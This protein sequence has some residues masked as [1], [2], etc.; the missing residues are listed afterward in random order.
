MYFFFHA[1]K[2]ACAFFLLSKRAA[3]FDAELL[4]VLV[5]ELLGP[6]TGLKSGGGGGR[7]STAVVAAFRGRFVGGVGGC[8]SAA[9]GGGGRDD[10]DAED[11]VRSMKGA[12]AGGVGMESC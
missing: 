5:A 9:G 1:N 11:M 4:A 2:S 3:D 8:S 7:D 10:L 6:A 12:V